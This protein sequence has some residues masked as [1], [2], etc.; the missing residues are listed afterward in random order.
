[1]QWRPRHLGALSRFVPEMHCLSKE[2]YL[3]QTKGLTTM[4]CSLWWM[5]TVTHSFDQV[6]GFRHK[7]RCLLQDNSGA[8]PS[9]QSPGIGGS[10]RSVQPKPR[11]GGLSG[12]ESEHRDECTVFV[13]SLR[14][15]IQESDLEALFAPCGDVRGVRLGRDAQTGRHRVR[16]SVLQNFAL[17]AA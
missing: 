4:C 10:R 8:G 7:Q 17:S 9:G 11:A 14:D 3:E 2:P 1:M 15:T 5:L 16:S 13:K 12:S 6:L